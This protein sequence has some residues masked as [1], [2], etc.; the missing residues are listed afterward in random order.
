MTTI[1]TLGSHCALQVLKGAK[2][3]GFRTLVVTERKRERFYRRFKFIDDFLVLNRFADI[4]KPNS[5]SFLKKRD[6]VII[7]HGTLISEVGSE[8]VENE[9]HVP[10]FGNRNILRW[11]ADREL[12]EKLTREARLRSPKTFSSPDKIDRLVIAKLPGARGGLGYFLASDAESYRKN[13]K[14]LQRKGVIGKNTPVFIQEYVVGVP[15]YFQYFSSILKNELEFFGIDRR[16]ETT[17]DAIGRIPAEHQKGLLPSYIVVGNS[18]LVLR[19]SLLEEA[20]QMGE[21]FVDA[22][23]KLVPPGMIGPF[24][25]EGVY[26]EDAEF[27]TFEFSARIVAGTNLYISGSPYF[28]LIYDEPMS[29]GR[30]IAL[31]IKNGIES[32]S[33]G[34]LLT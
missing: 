23:K 18:P 25:I 30:R 11:E 22:V 31:E 15:V 28:S 24:C 16:Y 21:R 33:L 26:N 34:K 3:E 10:I 7:P 6:A 2:D 9:L 29:M 19:E 20:Y 5:I 4:T 8:E 13:L 27:V 17:V 1:A 12:K 32:K 14:E